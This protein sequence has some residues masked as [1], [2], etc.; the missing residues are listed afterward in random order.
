VFKDGRK[1]LN[2]DPEERRGRPRVSHTNENCVIVEDLIR[3]DRN[4]KSS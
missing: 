4:V 2:D 1:A 3:G